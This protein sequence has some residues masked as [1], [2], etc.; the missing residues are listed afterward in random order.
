MGEWARGSALAGATLVS[1]DLTC[2]AA[3]LLVR[4]RQLTW[5]AAVLGCGLGIFLGDLGLWLIGRLF[6]R[7]AL[8]WSWLRRRLPEDRLNRVHEWFDTCGWR[9]VVA[10]RFLPGSRLPFFVAAG[11]FGR[12]TDRFVISALL[13]ALLWTPLVVLLVALLGDAIVPRLL[14][15][16][17]PGWLAI[18]A[19]VGLI[20]AIHRMATLALSH[21]GRARLSVAFARIRAW[22]FWPAWLF[23]AP[24]IP[25]IGWLALRHRGLTTPTAA[26]PGIPHGGIV[27]ESKI[28]ILRRLPE[29]WTLA[30]D[31]VPSGDAQSR[32]ALL[33]E[34]LRQRQWSYP[35]VLKPD[36]GQR[37][38]G[39]KLIR[40]ETAAT[41]YLN[42]S[43]EPLIA[44][45]YHPGPYE[46]GVFYARRPSEARG[47]VFS[48]TDKQFPAIIGDGVSS[49][50]SLIRGH[51]RYRMQAGVFL[52]RLADR[53]S[54][55]L[56]AGERLVLA[57]AGNHCQGTVFRDGSHLW[58]PALESAIDGIAQE[59]PGF[60]FGRFDIRYS[61]PDAFRHG[62]DFFIIEL[63]GALSESTD[64]YDP[65]GS[66]TH[67]YAVLRRQWSLLFEIGA[68]NRRRGAQPSP[69]SEVL[70]DAVAYYRTR[71]V[72]LISD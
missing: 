8:E 7:Q 54:Q 35:I 29:R 27:G 57:I 3:G 19:A 28:E 30:A 46:A 62:R 49:I 33:R 65:D 45:P 36:A 42:A 26:N 17:G 32:L 60:H 39:V 4:A 13:A 43:P 70:R 61:D 15:L 5:P 44:Q 72:P 48:I 37:G 20:I 25:W 23:Y 34:I 47:R 21:A 24:I 68:A 67:A 51:P 53:A 58:T 41:S 12:R 50:E 2:I 1:E 63:N 14:R 56:P 69:L 22:E 6:G 16:W 9:A 66:L 18:L 10:S 71:R 11:V 59:I 52:A 64:I 38:V 55:V 31:L 40:D